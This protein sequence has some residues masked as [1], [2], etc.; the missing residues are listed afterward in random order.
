MT[1]TMLRVHPEVSAAL[2]RGG[3]VVA[4][5]S[6]LIAHGLPWPLNLETARAAETIV[7]EAGATPATIAVLAGRP[8]IG[9]NDEQLEYLASCK[10]VVKAS[11]RDL[12]IA[13]AQGR[14]ASTTVA[15]TMMLANLVGIRLFATG[16]IGGAHRDNSVHSWDISADLCELSR[17][18]VCVV[19]AGAK[20]ILD[21][22]RTLEIL[23]TQGVPVIGF[24]TDE[25]P[26]FYLR[27]SGER[28]SAR[29]DDED[30]AA[31]ALNAHWSLQGAGVVIAQPV[32]KHFALE[33][34]DFLAALSS[35][36]KQAIGHGVRGKDLTP[37]LLGRLADLTEGQTLKANHALV[38]ANAR[39][40]ARIACAYSQILVPSYHA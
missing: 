7:R 22:P 2:R 8:C 32:D 24:G 6:T 15:A 5:E 29:V 21:I 9:L 19:C 30:Q 38:L 11:R 18:P 28:L 25:F 33:P 39:L 35:A 36:E 3:P 26:A 1:K 31:E 20:S 37:F 4:L 40:A 13:I 23:E 10:D 27:S 12:G 14:T 17:T 34:D 16:G